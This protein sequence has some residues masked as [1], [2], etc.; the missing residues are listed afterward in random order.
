MGVDA[1]SYGIVGMLT[2]HALGFRTNNTEHMR[3]TTG[4]NV[5]IGTTNPQAKL[6]V[7]GSAKIL[8]GTGSNFLDVGRNDLE[9]VTI[10]VNDLNVT[11]TATQDSDSDDVHGFIL[12]RVFA[13]TGA[14]Y[15]DIRKDGS[16][17]L[18]IDSAGNVGIGTAS[19]STKL[20]V[21][22]TAET[23]LRVGSSNASSNV[24]LELRD[25]NSP[26]GQ[27]TVITYN[28]AIGETYFN[29]ALSSAT[30]D[31][32]FQSGE[33]GSASDFFTLSNSGGNSIVQLSTTTGDSFITYE[34]STNE[35]AIASDGD[36]RLTTPTDQDV[37]FIS[38]GGNIDM[39]QAGGNVDMGGQLTVDGNGIFNSN[40]GVGTASPSKILHVQPESTTDDGIRLTNSAGGNLINLYQENSTEAFI[41]MYSNNVEKIQ[42]RANGNSYFNG[43]NVGI[44]TTNPSYK[45][46]VSGTIRATGDVIAYSDARVKENV[47]TIPNALDKVKAMRGVG[48]NKIGEE[49]RSVGVIAQ[50]MLEVMPEAVHQDEQGMYSVA[51]GNLVGVLIE[52]MKEQQAQIDE[53]KARLDGAAK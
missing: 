3:I 48:Y 36:L 46:D 47:E 44:G 5:G 32:H 35:L 29:N 26:T 2:N 31:F 34:D 12:D 30:T 15:F 11:F 53:L 41:R 4:G 51:Y 17:Q 18:R 16:T 50:E 21:V 42:L 22:G 24:V 8:S 52:A 49:K 1:S 45:L 28:N 6:D 27:G 38:S 19:P 20:H 39:T 40:V 10:A 25:E 7:V 43:G 37:F 33:Y 9:K 23:R 14:N 13:G